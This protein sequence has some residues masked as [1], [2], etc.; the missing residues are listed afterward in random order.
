MWW[1]FAAEKQHFWDICPNASVVIVQF[2]NAR[3]PQSAQLT[4]ADAK[5]QSISEFVD[6]ECIFGADLYPC[7]FSIMSSSP[8]RASTLGE[9][10]IQ[11]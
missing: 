9:P 2:S 11:S 7:L 4:C 3:N 10:R 8:G 6:L 5:M 1:G